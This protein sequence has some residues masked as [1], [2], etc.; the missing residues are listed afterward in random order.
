MN[1]DAIATKSVITLKNSGTLL[2]ASRLL[3]E[4]GIR[5]LPVVDDQNRLVGV[6]TDRDIKRVSASEATSL[7]IHEL[8]YLLDKL[9]VTKVMT[10]NPVT[11]TS[12]TTV[13]DAASLMV[14]RKI[15]CL[16]VVDGGKLN[17][18]VTYID[19]LRLLAQGTA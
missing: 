19:M 14:E 18:I 16:P 15:G 4:K 1:V 12:S 2:D 17:G 3:R 7:D 11:V 13:R 9:D 10:K 6:I 8:L 5:H